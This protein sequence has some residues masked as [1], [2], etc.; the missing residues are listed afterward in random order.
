MTIDELLLE[1]RVKTIRLRK[2]GTELIL[3]GDQENLDESLVHEL[4]TH[5]TSLFE[6][7]GSDSDTWW[8]PPIIITPEMLPLADLSQEQ[9]EE[10]V[11]AVPGGVGNV[12]DIYALAPLQKGILFHHMLGGEG[13]QYL[14]S[15]LIGFESRARLNEYLEAMQ[16]VIDRHD[17]LRTAV[18]WEGMAEPVQVVLRKV[19]LPVEEVEVNGA[20]GDVAGQLYDRFNPRSYRID[21][22]QAPLLRAYIAEDK[23][24]DRWLMMFLLHHLAGDHMTEEAVQREIAMHLLGQTDRLPEPL[25]FRN[26]VA[27]AR[28]GM[29][30]EEHEAFFRS[31]LGDVEEPTAPYGLLDVQGDG[32]GIE[33]A[34]VLVKT[35]VER[36]LRERGRKLGVSVASL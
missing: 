4:R 23:E 19:A 6:L 29:K 16:A 31:M 27:Q 18:M 10:I 3:L 1:L 11:R 32:S 26:L 35:G 2:S 36:R 33:Q 30:E 28:L 8:S 25:P 12:Q 7:I 22:R 15:M 17:I 34:S 13:D 14:V 21:V 20:K 24:K 9:I 5:K